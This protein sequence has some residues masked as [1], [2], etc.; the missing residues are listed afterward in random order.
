MVGLRIPWIAPP[1][2][3]EYLDWSC[4]AVGIANRSVKHLKKRS[5]SISVPNFSVSKAQNLL[6]PNLTKPGLFGT[7]SILAR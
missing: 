3:Y 4:G 2:L 5:E 1:H 6:H 7:E